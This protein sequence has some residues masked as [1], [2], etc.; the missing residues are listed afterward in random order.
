MQVPRIIHRLFFDRNYPSVMPTSWT[1]EPHIVT[2]R[3]RSGTV[4]CPRPGWIVR[5]YYD[6]FTEPAVRYVTADRYGTGVDYS[7]LP[8]PHP[9]PFEVGPDRMHDSGWWRTMAVTLAEWCA[10]IASCGQPQQTTR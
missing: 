7:L 10:F 8:D 3:D 9:Q 1:C 2:L 6:G 5:G 4:A